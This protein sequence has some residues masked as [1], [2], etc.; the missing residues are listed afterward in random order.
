MEISLTRE[1]YDSANKVIN[2]TSKEIS[3]LKKKSDENGLRVLEQWKE[4][5]YHERS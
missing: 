3:P 2:S 4:F 5:D 1:I